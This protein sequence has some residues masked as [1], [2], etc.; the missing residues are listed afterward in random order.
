MSEKPNRKQVAQAAGVSEATVSRVFNNP[1]SVSADKIKRVTE[2]ARR[3]RYTPNKYA[4]ALRRKGSGV[5]LF[6]ENENDTRHY[7]WTRIRHYNAFYAEIIRALSREADQ[8]MFHLRLASVSSPE[9]ILDLEQSEVCDGIIGF[10][11]E[12]ERSV[13]PFQKISIPYVCCHHT[14]TFKGINRVSTDNFDGGFQQA[15]LLR[16]RGYQAPVYVT[17]ALDE[18]IAH[19]RRLNGFLSGFPKDQIRVIQ[20]DPSFAGGLSIAES[21]IP[22][23]INGR[24]DSIGVVNDLTAVGIV[25]KLLA[26]GI[27]IPDQIGIVGYDNLPI[28]SVQPVNLTSIDLSL[29]EVYSTAFRSLLDMIRHRQPVAKVIPPIV[30][31]GESI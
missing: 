22:E 10:N 21:L 1:E 13:E 5:I 31:A 20:T 24:I 8:S 30:K 4:S 9:E 14:E 23:I 7:R 18:T 6:L 3:L 26:N 17:G 15:S 2:A 25:Q 19:K 16:D 12:D 29:P 11:F 27:G 28:I